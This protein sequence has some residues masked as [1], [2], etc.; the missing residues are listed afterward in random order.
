MDAVLHE[1]AS[2]TS[3]RL[4]WKASRN[5]GCSKAVPSATEAAP[6]AGRRRGNTRATPS[7]LDCPIHGGGTLSGLSKLAGTSRIP[8]IPG[9][10][11]R[12]RHVC[13]VRTFFEA[14]AYK[15]NGRQVRK[16]LRV[17]GLSMC[18]IYRIIRIWIV[19]MSTE[20]P[21]TLILPGG[22]HRITAWMVHLHTSS[23]FLQ[24]G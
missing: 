22:Q 8:Q 14:R 20:R 17:S 12:C 7:D 5:G 11:M 3:F 21:A 18:V 16:T 23:V 10:I 1:D 4:T 9:R 24:V 2:E 15:V 13:P 19:L 6:A